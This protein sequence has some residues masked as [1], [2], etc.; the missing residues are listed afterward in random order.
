MMKDAE[1]AALLN[2]DLKAQMLTK[3]MEKASLFP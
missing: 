1:N 3:E 2:E